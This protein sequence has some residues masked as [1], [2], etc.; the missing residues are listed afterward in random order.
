MSAVRTFLSIPALLLAMTGLAGCYDLSDP[1]GPRREDFLGSASA[2]DPNKDGQTQGEQAQAERSEQAVTA[3]TKVTTASAQAL[4]EHA[5][6]LD[7]T[8]VQVP[9]GGISVA[10]Y[11]ARYVHPSPS[12]D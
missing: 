6:A 11:V 9:G 7:A 10:E 2:S 1:T 3:G 12:A 4:P 5:A 8:V